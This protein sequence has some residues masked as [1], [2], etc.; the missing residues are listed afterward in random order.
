LRTAVEIYRIARS[1]LN[2]YMWLLLLALLVA[3]ASG[4]GLCPFPRPLARCSIGA[5]THIDVIV[6]SFDWHR[7]R[8]VERATIKFLKSLIMATACAVRLHVVASPAN[9]PAL[10]SALA[11]AGTEVRQ[12]AVPAISPV[13]FTL[14]DE[15]PLAQMAERWRQLTNGTAAMHHSGVSSFFKFYLDEFFPHLDRVIV[16]DA[17]MLVAEDIQLLY[18]KAFGGGGT[19]MSA[20][21][22]TVFTF[23]PD[24]AGAPV[25]ALCGCLVAI[26]LDELRRLGGAQALLLRV[27]ETK[28][29]FRMGEQ[30]VYA[31][32]CR[33]SPQY[34]SAFEDEWNTS[35]CRTERG[36]RRHRRCYAIAHFNCHESMG[37]FHDLVLG[38]YKADLLAVEACPWHALKSGLCRPVDSN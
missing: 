16:F 14:Y 23:A 6:V 3:S 34:F 21:S 25:C 15:F 13:M 38:P 12:L 33:F 26:K 35:F 27:P 17:D 30:G 31:S 1:P 19:N 11:L 9:T 36:R 18:A 32:L 4:S 2:S 24:F 10:R 20:A 8:D 22:T 7:D 5:A 29:D 37:E 28:R